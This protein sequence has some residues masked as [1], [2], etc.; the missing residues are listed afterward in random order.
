MTH[1]K[2]KDRVTGIFWFWGYRTP[3]VPSRWANN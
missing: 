2:V 3:R 1:L